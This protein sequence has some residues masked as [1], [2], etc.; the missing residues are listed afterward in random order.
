VKTGL[1]STFIPQKNK[2]PS[3]KKIFYT[4]SI[5]ICLLITNSLFS[6]SENKCYLLE[7]NNNGETEYIAVKLSIKGNKV[8]ADLQKR[9]TGNGINTVITQ[10]KQGVIEGDKI[11]F[12]S[13]Q[14][15]KVNTSETKQNESWSFNGDS[16]I[17]GEDVLKP[18]DCNI[19]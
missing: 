10:N 15:A 8:D 7:K 6:Q 13:S 2:N 18:G 3:M 17:V 19:N 11:I 14:E 16:L 9:I 1:W 12:T 4:A 5:L